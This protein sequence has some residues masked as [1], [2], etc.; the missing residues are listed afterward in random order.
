MEQKLCNRINLEV[1]EQRLNDFKSRDTFDHECWQI[2]CNTYALYREY[3]TAS[4]F[5]YAPAYGK[6]PYNDE[7]DNETIGMEKYI[8]FVADIEGKLYE[9]I[10][11]S[12]NAEFNEYGIMEEPTIYMPID[13]NKISK[14]N[15][16]FE[17][18]LFDLINDL[19]GLLYEYKKE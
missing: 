9:H 14:N 16:E 8:S 12:I 5:R 19:N 18:R 4:V 7:Y 2:A 6:D 11:E 15:F 3:P 1:F 10:E 17:T 13:E